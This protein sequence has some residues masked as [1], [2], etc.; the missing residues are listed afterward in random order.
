MQVFPRANVLRK[1]RKFVKNKILIFFREFLLPAQRFSLIKK[2]P[3]DLS[4][5]STLDTEE[6]LRVQGVA[7]GFIPGEQAKGQSRE[8]MS[9][10]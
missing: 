1:T 2:H 3:Y 7:D 9:E 8:T 4:L 10:L 5:L 6:R